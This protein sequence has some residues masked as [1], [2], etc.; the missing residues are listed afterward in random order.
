[1]TTLSNPTITSDFESACERMEKLGYERSEFETQF[2]SW[3]D[4]GD[5]VLIASNHDLGS[6]PHRMLGMAHP[7]GADEDTPPH[8]W[9][10]EWG[11]GW[12]YLYD[13]RLTP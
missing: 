6:I 10:G 9:D 1:M 13:I 7:I 4:R 2:R 12:R 3:L 8:M 5:H 11:L